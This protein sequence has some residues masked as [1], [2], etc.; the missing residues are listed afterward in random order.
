[1]K[2]IEIRQKTIQP[3]YEAILEATEKTL[4]DGTTLAASFKVIYPEVV[5]MLLNDG[6][7]IEVLCGPEGPI[8]YSVSCKNAEEGRKGVFT[9]K[10]IEMPTFLDF[11]SDLK[12]NME[13]EEESSEDEEDDEDLQE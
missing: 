7:D 10:K 1:M 8:S 9:K 3:Q 2:A 5:E 12:G 4:C 6:F 13:D 11:L